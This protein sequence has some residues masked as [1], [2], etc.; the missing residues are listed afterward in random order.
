MLVN[1]LVFQ[2]RDP[3]VRVGPAHVGQA[4]SGLGAGAATVKGGKRCNDAI[5]WSTLVVE[6][7]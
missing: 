6:N 2:R 3:A 5:G 1:W 4:E 7:S